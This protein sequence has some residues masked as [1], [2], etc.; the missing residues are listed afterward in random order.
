MIFSEEKE[1]LT[2]DISQSVKTVLS[3]MANLIRGAKQNE[4]KQHAMSMLD[5]ITGLWSS[6]WAQ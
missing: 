4:A 2:Y 1:E 5:E 6:N 3:W